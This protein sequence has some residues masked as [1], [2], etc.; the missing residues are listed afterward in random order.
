MDVNG[1]RHVRKFILITVTSTPK[2]SGTKPRL[3]VLDAMRGFAIILMI[4]DHVFSALESSGIKNPIVDYSRLTVTR[5][6]MPLFMI[7]S[8]IVWGLFGLHFKR[9]LQVLALAGVLNTINWFLWP[10]FNFPEILFVWA[11][12]AIGW[13]AIVRYPIIVMII[14]YTQ[15]T[16]WQISWQAFQPG[17]LVIFICAGVLLARAPIHGINQLWRERRTAKFLAPLAA[18]GRRPLTIYGT[19]LV[20]LAVIVAAANDRFTSLF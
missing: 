11:L 12:L 15:T 20:L 14:G 6:S 1:E 16:Y 4:A 7:A 18:V 2:T 9:W 5:F 3:L 10:D 19:H 17:E 13:R 8:G